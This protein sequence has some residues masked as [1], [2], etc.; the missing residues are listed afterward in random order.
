M[1]AKCIKDLP[2]YAEESKPDETKPL[3]VVIGNAEKSQLEQGVTAVRQETCNLIKSFQSQREK[4]CEYFASAEKSANDQLDR[5]NSSGIL[6][7]LAFISLGGFSG[8][9]LAYR[10]SPLRKLTYSAVLSGAA[11]AL[12]YPNEARAAS[13]RVYAGVKKNVRE[14]YRQYVWPEEEG[15]VRTAASGQS[16]GAND[17]KK[18]QQQSQETADSKDKVVKLDNESI[19][20]AKTS[21]EIKG[22]KGQSSDV[23]KDMYTTRSK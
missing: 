17:E 21:K 3:W 19:R 15:Q 9:I 13:N 1:S 10:R 22:D 23:D 14:A 18:M 5:L 8:F 7:K 11:A 20:S 16:S 2:L 12:C 6:P 4:A